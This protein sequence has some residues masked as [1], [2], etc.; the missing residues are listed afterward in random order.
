MVLTCRSTRR[1]LPDGTFA[2]PTPIIQADG[3]AL[4]I[5]Q[6]SRQPELN[7][8]AEQTMAF[9][10][11]TAAFVLTYY[12]DARDLDP[13]PI[14]PDDPNKVSLS[15][16]VARQT[17][18]REKAQLTEL[19]RLSQAKPHLRMFLD[20]PA[21]SGK[22]HVVR[23][24]L[25]YAEAYATNLKATFD[26]RTI[27]VTAMSGVAA[28]SIGGET[29]HSAA[30]MN[31]NIDSER[32]SSWINARLLIIDEC[33]FMDVSQVV[34]LDEKLRTLMHRH[35]T[36]FG[37]L[38]ILFCGDFR[39]LEPVAGT[40]LYSPRHSDKKWVNSINCYI[41]LRGLHRFREDPE[42]GMILR[43]LRDAS[44]T[45][46]DLHAINAC[47]IG[48][49]CIPNNASYCV[50]SNSDRSAI[51]AGIFSNFLTQHAT[52]SPLLPAN[53]LVI[54]GSNIQRKLDNGSMKDMH[55][56]DLLYM[57]QNCGDFRVTA[58]SRSGKGHFV[59]PF[60]KLYHS[61]PL[62]FVS[63][64]DVP[65]GHANGTR[66]ILR[67]VVLNPGC[68]T[69]V[70]NI[71]GH[72]CHSIEAHYV[73]YLICTLDGNSSK[74][75]HVAPKTISCYVRAPLPNHF[76][77]A[78]DATINFK[79]TMTQLP[80]LVNNATT[81]HKLQGQTKQNLVISVWSKK[82]NWNYV[83]LSRVTTREGLFLVSPLPH[84]VDFSISRDLAQMLQTLRMQQPNPVELD[85]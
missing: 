30:A 55:L 44:H 27:I 45:Q 14:D 23:A 59:D 17:F 77:A 62:M 37:G 64:D 61:V 73:Q 66:V 67:A 84:D 22:S 35:N 29:L 72:R 1:R 28:T 68:T 9:Q 52:P 13:P 57:F 39:Q 51:N 15:P 82:K 33:S 85:I 65:N 26:M 75:F 56:Q 42:W 31:R 46:N 40:P 76:G 7:F 48:N 53:V 71:D 69:E 11:V 43:R 34:T 16:A 10:I 6:W 58:G 32:E 12:N 38:H 3:T 18:N 5:V 78:T 4:S 8:D 63:N 50:Y 19:A 36:L 83:A 60:L 81:G 80:V 70:V 41:E 47:I 54:R 74:I 25:G 20:G 49:R 79:I 21:G 2:P 24:L